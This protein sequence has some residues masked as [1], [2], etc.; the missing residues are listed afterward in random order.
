MIEPLK[1]A[2]LLDRR[3]HALRGDLERSKEPDLALLAETL[4]GAGLP[5]AVIGGVALQIHQ[6]EPRTTLDVDVAVIRRKDIPREKLVL[7]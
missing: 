5:Y 4:E 6:N 2:F 7:V 1:A 3:W